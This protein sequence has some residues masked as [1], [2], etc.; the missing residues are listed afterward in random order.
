MLA[1]VD[2]TRALLATAAGG[3]LL[4]ALGALVGLLVMVRGQRRLRRA[5]ARMEEDVARLPPWRSAEQERAA[6]AAADVLVSTL[7]YL[8]AVELATAPGLKAEAPAEGDEKRWLADDVRLRWADVRP[9]EQEFRGACV[10]AHV[11]LPERVQEALE[12]VAGLVRDI[13]TAQSTHV[14]QFAQGG[15]D[16]R[17]FV[18][19]FGELPV[20]RLAEQ[21]EALKRLL[22]PLVRPPELAEAPGRGR[23]TP[24]GLP[25]VD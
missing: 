23:W 4:A 9:Q 14:A 6:L 17:F 22:R 19:G 13:R 8:D 12:E 7:R 24:R 16:T 1:E 20:R 10:L 25:A 21:R 15:H 3:G 18:E 5:L 11:H 2:L